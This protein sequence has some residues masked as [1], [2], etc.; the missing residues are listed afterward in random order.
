MIHEILEDATHRMDQ[1]VEHTRQE[2]AKIRTGRANPELLNSIKVPYYGTETPLYQLANISVPEAR[3]ITIQPFDK[4]IIRE[5]E[6]A[7]LDSN[8]GLTPNNNG[9]VILLPIP[10]LSEERRK[11]LIKIVHHQ[12]EEGRIAIRNVRRDANQQLK[13]LLSEGHISEDEIKRSEEEVQTLTDKHIE[14][15]NTLLELKEK[16]IMEF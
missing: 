9:D 13:N 7:I 12:V 3:L 11:D 10:P 4:S 6:K 5:M 1:T 15:L 2:L 8:L 14:H 16:E